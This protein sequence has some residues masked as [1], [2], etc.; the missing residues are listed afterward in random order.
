MRIG[1]S[2]LF[3]IFDRSKHEVCNIQRELAT[4][5]GSSVSLSL[6]FFF[7][8]L[9]LFVLV[10]LCPLKSGAGILD[11][12]TFPSHPF[13]GSLFPASAHSRL[14]A[15][16][17]F[18]RRPRVYLKPVLSEAPP[19][20][21]SHLG[22]SQ[23]LPSTSSTTFCWCDKPDVEWPYMAS[24]GLHPPAFMHSPLERHG[25]PGLQSCPP[26]QPADQSIWGTQST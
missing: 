4:G 3:A 22:K 1:N 26:W 20:T 6:S 14:Y 25:V 10:S 11:L 2:K 12:F 15:V 7:F 13:F 8:L 18:L 17:P 21:D 16:D 19:A 23:L 24:S 5:N 9:S